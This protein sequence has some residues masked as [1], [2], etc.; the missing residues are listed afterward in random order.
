M[1]NNDDKGESSHVMRT[2]YI[3]PGGALTRLRSG[4]PE[5]AV[6]IFIQPVRACPYNTD[7]DEKGRSAME[8]PVPGLATHARKLALC[9]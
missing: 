9:I 6:G 2:G 7:L 4:S 8:F 1:V 5:A 3:R